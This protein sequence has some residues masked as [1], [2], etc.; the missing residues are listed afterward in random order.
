[1]HQN[2]THTD[3]IDRYL[4]GKLPESERLALEESMRQDPMLEGEI[5]WEK[6]IYQAM[7]ETRR[8]AL[9]QRLDQVSVSTSTW[10]GGKIAAV[11]GTA[12]LVGAGA[13]YYNSQSDQTVVEATAPAATSTVT[14]PQ[15]FVLE[16]TPAAP[17][18]AP[19]ETTVPAADTRPTVEIEQ[20]LAVATPT[21]TIVRPGVV[22]EFEED[23]PTV[24][25]DDFKAPEKQALQSN[26]YQTEEVAVEARTDGEYDF[27]YQFYDGKLFLHGNFDGYPYQVIALNTDDRKKLF[28]EFESTYYRISEH[29][30]VTPLVAIEDQKLIQNLQKLSQVE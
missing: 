2:F 10:S 17:T 20:P 26:T 11:V 4:K 19:E 28:L 5:G 15:A 8:A 29:A 12:L 22:S 24:D 13:F 7:G 6:D 21:P 27:H 14:Y 3:L 16:H 9:K 18:V 23:M 1:M 25:Y 30:E